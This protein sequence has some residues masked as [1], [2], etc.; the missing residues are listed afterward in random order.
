MTNKLSSLGSDY[1]VK[2]LRRALLVAVFLL[3]GTEAAVR[4]CGA[5]D[6]PCIPLK[7]QLDT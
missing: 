4:L 2:I 3:I 7:V 1:S 6:S 5:M